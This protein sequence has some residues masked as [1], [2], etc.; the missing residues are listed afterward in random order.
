MC[1]ARNE[2]TRGTAKH[3][4]A[5]TADAIA[6]ETM[7][8]VSAVRPCRKIGRD[9]CIKNVPSSRALRLTAHTRY[10]RVFFCNWCWRDAQS[11]ALEALSKLLPKAPSRPT[12]EGPKTR[13]SLPFVFFALLFAFC[14]DKKAFQ[15]RPPPLR[16]S[17]L[18]A[19]GQY[20]KF[21]MF[22]AGQKTLPAIA[23]S[24]QVSLNFCTPPV[25]AP[26]PSKPPIHTLNRNAYDGNKKTWPS[27]TFFAATNAV[28][29]GPTARSSMPRVLLKNGPCS[30]NPTPKNRAVRVRS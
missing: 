16:K 3:G 18:C 26:L 7:L 10:H 23:T 6:A 12:T 21:T 19:G 22:A 17:T 11:K 14:H 28:V 30:V 27:A 1:P 9:K 20:M 13:S 5:E 8:K 2:R 24:Y 29:L 25:K 15:K 4:A